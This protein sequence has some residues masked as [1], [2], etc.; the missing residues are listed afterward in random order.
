MIDRLERYFSKMTPEGREHLFRLVQYVS[1]GM[2]I[3]GCILIIIEIINGR[4]F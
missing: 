1:Y 4:L 2:L 3:L